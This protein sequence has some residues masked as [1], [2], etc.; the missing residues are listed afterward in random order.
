VTTGRLCGTL[1]DV[2]APTTS[3]RAIELGDIVETPSDISEDRALGMLRRLLGQG[4]AQW[5]CGEQRDAVQAAIVRRQDVL[6]IIKTGAG[7]SMIPIIPA[8]LEKNMTTVIVLP[9]KSLVDDYVRKLNDMRVPFEHFD[10]STARLRGTTSLILVSAD[11]AKT[12]Q[13]KQAAG[14]LHLRKPIV[15]SC[16]D[17]GHFALTEDDRFRRVALGNMHELRM[18]D[19]TQLIVMS[20]TVRKVSVPTLIASFMLTEDVC[21]FRTGSARPEIRYVLER[22]RSKSQILSRT[23]NLVR[24]HTGGFASE[25]RGLIFVA[26]IDDGKALKEMLKVDFY[27]GGGG[28]KL[29]REERN[30]NDVEKKKMV[31]RWRAGEQRWMICTPAF[32]AGNDYGHVRVVIHTGSPKEM[33]GYTQEK[34]RAGRDKRPALS[35]ILPRI[36]SPTASGPA[37]LAPGAIDHKG[38]RVMFDW[39]HG[40]DRSVC[41]RY[42]ITS[43]CDAEEGVRCE[44]YANAQPCAVCRPEEEEEEEQVRTTM[45]SLKRGKEATDA[46]A[47]SSGGAFEVSFLQAKKRRIELGREDQ[48]YVEAMRAALTY[49]DGVCALC[50]VLGVDDDDPQHTLF[51]CGSLGVFLE[52]TATEYIEWRDAIRYSEEHHGAICYMCH[53]PQKDD[54]LHRQFGSKNACDFPDVVALTAFGVFNHHRSKAE[55]AFGMTWRDAKVYVSWLNAKPIKGHESNITAVL[56]WYHRFATTIITDDV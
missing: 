5:T 48:A 52:T 44:E 46:A 20:A 25:D 13:W 4:E 39:L 24:R 45:K 32:G 3:A 16:F 43:F 36:L 51:Q 29:T 14:E 26:Y 6:A 7:K 23:S 2:F 37:P 49:F 8:M 55:K 22:A 35:Y 50:K 17:E 27:A 42:V 41:S 1:S 40:S 18:F 12:A 11:M 19:C 10:G 47:G 31:A 30:K 34:S 33:M 9:L 54:R 38:V 53:V 15:R 21:I 56:L 28:D